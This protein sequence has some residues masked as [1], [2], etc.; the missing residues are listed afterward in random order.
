MSCFND[1]G[2]R[3]VQIFPITAPPEITPLSKSRSLRTAAS[4]NHQKDHLGKLVESLKKNIR[5]SRIIKPLYEQLTQG[6]TVAVDSII[7]G[8]KATTQ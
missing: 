2:G 7:K 5:A 3:A 6:N 4:P 1:A 8:I